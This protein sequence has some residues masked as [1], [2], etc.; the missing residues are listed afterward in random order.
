MSDI[1]SFS[2]ATINCK[3][4]SEWRE[5]YH[6][7]RLKCTYKILEYYHPK[8]W[9]L[10]VSIANYNFS[11]FLRDKDGKQYNSSEFSYPYTNRE[12]ENSEETLEKRKNVEK[13]RE[14]LGV[15]QV[16]LYGAGKLDL[17]NIQITENNILFKDA[18]AGYLKSLEKQKKDA[19]K[20]KQSF[21]KMFGESNF[22]VTKN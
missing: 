4:F 5:K 3:F 10:K 18:Y 2:A 22:I 13:L 15:F 1:I 19:E 17:P 8:I 16:N 21:S 20:I 14:R 6:T 7:E 11:H 12:N 9:V